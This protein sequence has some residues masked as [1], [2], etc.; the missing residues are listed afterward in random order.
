[1]AKFQLEYIRHNSDLTDKEDVDAA[2]SSIPKDIFEAYKKTFTERVDGRTNKVI[3]VWVVSWILKGARPLRL[4]ELCSLIAVEK[5]VSALDR[6]I[7][8][9]LEVCQNFITQSSGF[10]DFAHATVKEFFETKYEESPPLPSEADIARNC[11]KYLKS[12]CT[13]LDKHKE[14]DIP[15]RWSKTLPRAVCYEYKALGYVGRHWAFHTK[16]GEEDNNVQKAALEILGPKRSRDSVL[17]IE[18]YMRKTEFVSGQSL[19]HIVAENGMTKI[20]ENVVWP[21]RRDGM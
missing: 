7:N 9:L 15:A 21:K 4:H 2:L 19:L 3:L 10:V 18:A 11:L 17:K 13:A 20:C 5:G 6:N 16:K 1:L 8:S 12:I 14:V